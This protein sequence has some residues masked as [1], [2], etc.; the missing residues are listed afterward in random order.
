M[1]GIKY[2]ISKEYLEESYMKLRAM[3]MY[4]SRNL[5]TRIHQSTISNPIEAG[6]YNSITVRMNENTY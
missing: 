5:V 6:I 3:K 1:N 4:F 2:L